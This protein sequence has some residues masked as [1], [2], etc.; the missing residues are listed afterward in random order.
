MIELIFTACL[1]A[2][3]EVCRE[4]HV[5]LAEGVTTQACLWQAQPHM[6]TWVASHPKWRIARWKC[7]PL[8]RRELK[9]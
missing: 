8:A 7:Q 9:I 2:S 3:P 6:A 5:V 1:S 4:Q